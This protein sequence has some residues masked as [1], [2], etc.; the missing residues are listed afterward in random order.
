[1][2]DPGTLSV[3]AVSNLHNSGRKDC[4]VYPD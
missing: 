4:E 3:K 1:M 2:L